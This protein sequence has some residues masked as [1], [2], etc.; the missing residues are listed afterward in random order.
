MK[1]INVIPLQEVSGVSFGMKRNDVRSI[2]GEAKEFKKTKNSKNTADD[3][4]FCHVYYDSN[5]ECEAIELFDNVEILINGLS[6]SKYDINSIK[7]IL[8]DAKRDDCGLISKSQSI[9]VFAPNNQIE[10]ILF[11]CKNYFK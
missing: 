10:S 9:G 7:S 1:T 4:G 11:G 2:F 3:L 6:I 8:P 5:N